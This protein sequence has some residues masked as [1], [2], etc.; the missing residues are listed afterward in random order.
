MKKDPG[1]RRLLEDDDDREEPTDGAGKGEEEEEEEEEG[2][3]SWQ[4]RPEG[5]EVKGR[6]EDKRAGQ[7]PGKAKPQEEPGRCGV[8]W[9]S[10]PWEV[11]AAGFA[12]H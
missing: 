1:K 5:E 2:R 3:L 11:R 9:W 7:R 10:P 4:C 12:S 8:L 6:Q